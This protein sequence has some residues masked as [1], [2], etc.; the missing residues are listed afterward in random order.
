MS[1]SWNT[2]QNGGRSYGSS[3]SYGSGGG[4]RR[5]GGSGGYQS[6]GSGGGY[7]SRYGGSGGGG[8]QRDGGYSQGGYRSNYGGSGGGQRQNYGGSG[9]GG[10]GRSGGNFV[11]GSA[12]SVIEIDSNKVGMVIG[13]GGGK[14][15][16]IQDNFN[17]HVKIGMKIKINY[18]LVFAQAAYTNQ[19]VIMN[20]LL[21]RDPGHNGCTGVTIKGEEDAI[22]QATQYIQELVAVK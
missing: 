4:Q 15:R 14:I 6:G 8:G 19:I 11:E 18:K 22:Q 9:G 1:E 13:R 7:N 20:I 3:R 12:S 21:D 2:E 16:E 17:V 5:E 10:G